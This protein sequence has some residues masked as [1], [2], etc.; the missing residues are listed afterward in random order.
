MGS[1]ENAWEVAR[2]S[3]H[4]LEDR[5]ACGQMGGGVHAHT[6]EQLQMMP[7]DP[8][9]KEKDQQRHMWAHPVCMAGHSADRVVGAESGGQALLL[10]ELGLFWAFPLGVL[11]HSRVTEGTLVVPSPP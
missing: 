5:C 8:V 3:S 7:C 10:S 11:Y 4:Q 1:I 6:C 9:R 2:S